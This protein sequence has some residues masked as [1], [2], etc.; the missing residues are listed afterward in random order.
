[1][2]ED[3]MLN[4]IPRSKGDVQEVAIYKTV[5]AIPKLQRLSLTLDS[6]NLSL[7]W[8]G[9]DI[10]K[11]PSFDEFHQKFQVATSGTSSVPYQSRY[12]HIRNALINSAL[13]ETLARGIFNCISHRNLFLPP[14]N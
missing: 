9:E 3:L 11:D 8:E 5:G 2:L 4:P 1:M 10:L 6:S 13:D 14:R 7:I 12:G